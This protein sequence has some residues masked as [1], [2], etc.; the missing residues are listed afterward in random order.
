MAN[1]RALS[2]IL[3][4]V[5]EAADIEGLTDRHTDAMLIKW[6]NLEWRRLRTKLADIGLPGLTVPT[7]IAALPT[8]PPVTTEQYLEVNW[9]DG[10]VGVYGIDVLLGTR[11]VPLKPMNFAQRRDFQHYGTIESA[12]TH[13]IP[14]TLP[15]E[16]TTTITAGKIALFPLATGGVNYRIWYL[17]V[18]VDITTTSNVFY[19]HDIW[20]SWLIQAMV[21]RVAQRDDDAQNT[22]A[23]AVRQQAEIWVEIKRS[24]QNMNL[25]ELPRRV[26]ANRRGRTRG[27]SRWGA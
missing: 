4:D 22:L 8:T 14:L 1:S 9:P 18:W 11:W 21:R 5:R 19:G 25:A 12:P 17:P 3:A 26:R 7:T 20:F 16:S 24:A 6:V 13:W 2:V 27:D 10:A 23:E 15:S